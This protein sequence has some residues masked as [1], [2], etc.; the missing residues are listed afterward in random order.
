MHIIKVNYA[1]N[2]I[3]KI[4]FRSDLS[5]QIKKLL[6]WRITTYE[7]LYH[8]IYLYLV[9]LLYFFYNFSCYIVYGVN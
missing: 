6:H 5:T 3:H 1:V 9:A 4:A 7:L 8:V 2:R